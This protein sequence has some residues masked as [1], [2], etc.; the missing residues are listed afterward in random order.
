MLYVILLLILAVLL[1]GSS[2]VLGA[3]GYVLGIVA[4]LIAALVVGFT[5]QINPF[6]VMFGSVAGLIGLL[7]AVVIILKLIEP[8]FRPWEPRRVDQIRAEVGKTASNTNFPNLPPEFQK[9]AD[10]LY[11]R[12]QK[13]K[14]S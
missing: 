13:E 11:Q 5:F 4:F 12:S 8:L 7:F 6:V 10:S 14:G 2:A 1:F 9:E 3:I